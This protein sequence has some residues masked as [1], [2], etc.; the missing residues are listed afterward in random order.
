MSLSRRRFLASSSVCASAVVVGLV[1]DGSLGKPIPQT[2]TPNTGQP[3]DRF[4]V[5]IKGD[6]LSKVTAVGFGPGTTAEHLKIQNDGSLTVKLTI[7][8]AAA[9]G[10]R[11]VVC[12]NPDGDGAIR[13]GF[14]IV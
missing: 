3:G 5:T 14:M 11:D 9:L 8:P 13:G 10:L 6:V 1:S 12:T 4:T 7:G 2:A